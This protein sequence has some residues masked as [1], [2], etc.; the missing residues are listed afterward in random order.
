M[1]SKGLSH[2]G[3]EAVSLNQCTNKGADVVNTGALHQVP[4]SFGARLAGAHLEIH[5]VKFITEIGVSVMEILADAHQ[6]LIESQSR[7]DADDGQIEGVGQSEANAV[8]TIFDHALQH[9]ARK[10]KPECRE[11]R[12]ARK[13]LSKPREERHAGETDAA[14]RTRAPK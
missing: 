14:M 2:A 4:Q 13:R 7:F 1:H 9:E 8:L 3:T 5:E 10:K 12:R 11:C 6:R